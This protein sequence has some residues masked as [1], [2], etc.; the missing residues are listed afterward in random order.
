MLWLTNKHR[1]AL[2]CGIADLAQTFLLKNGI[3]YGQNLID[4]QNLGFQMGGNRKG[5]PNVHSARIVFHRGIQQTATFGKLHDL[6]EFARDFPA[7]HA[8]DCAIEEDILPAREFRMKAGP[9][10]KQAADPAANLRLPF[11][12]FCDARQDLQQRRFAGPVSPNDA[13]HL[14]IDAP[15]ATDP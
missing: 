8:Q 15:P 6:I 1:P 3:P 7:R 5:Q 9:D 12:W 4:Q 10:F 13:Q 14:A 2:A 11:R